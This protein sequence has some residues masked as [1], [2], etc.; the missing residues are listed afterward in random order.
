MSSPNK[1]LLLMNKIPLNPT[2]SPNSTHK[3]LI[4][5]YLSPIRF[6]K[7]T[8]RP[9]RL[10]KLITT[11]K[12]LSDYPSLSTLQLKFSATPEISKLQTVLQ[13]SKNQLLISKK[14]NSMYTN[15]ST[16]RKNQ[17]YFKA[18]ITK[19]TPIPLVLQINNINILHHKSNKSLPKMVDATF[20][21]DF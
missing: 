6:R 9:K 1:Y 8:F 7:S 3:S 4:R 5:K 15:S 13:S 17:N 10:P 14:S 12:V 11:L 2:D 19:Q 20:N 16:Y 18:K 21:T